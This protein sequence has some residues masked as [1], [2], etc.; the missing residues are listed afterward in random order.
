MPNRIST[1]RALCHGELSEVPSKTGQ[2]NH[3]F[4]SILTLRGCFM[5]NGLTRKKNVS[6]FIDI[7]VEVVSKIKMVRQIVS[8]ILLGVIIVVGL[9]FISASAG[10]KQ[11]PLGF[12]SSQLSLQLIPR[13]T[14]QMA[15]FFEAREFPARMIQRL[16]D[17]CFFTV[18][19]ENKMN[20]Q[21]RLDLSAWVFL[22][23]QQSVSRIPRSKWPPVWKQLHIPQASQATF[24]WT[25]LPETLDFYA[26]ES[27]GGNIILQKTNRPFTLRAKFNIGKNDDPLIATV[28]HFHC[29][30]ARDAKG[31]L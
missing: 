16:S 2:S 25:L 19:I 30:D 20:K 18:I 8:R 10:D 11:P 4:G 22:T 24:R 26:N 17:Y 28:N 14:E 7:E 13:S 31:A 3:S 29:A 9:C 1:T 5:F 27:E 23:G 21:L 6:S 15:A 12:E